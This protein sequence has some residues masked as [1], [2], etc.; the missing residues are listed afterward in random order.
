MTVDDMY[1]IINFAINK[2]QNGTLIAEDFN[3]V[4]PLAESGFINYLLG[5]F[6]TYQNGR[7]VARVELGQNS[8]VRQRL[9]PIIKRAVLTI[10]AG[11]LCP[12]PANYIQADAMW[13]DGTAYK[14]VKWCDQDKW[15]ST[16]NSSIDKVATKPIY[17]LTDTG[18]EFAPKSIGVASLSYV[19][20]PTAIKWAF[21]LDVN[22]RRVYDASANSVQPVW[23]NVAIMEI[24]VRA[25]ALI[26]I[27]LQLREVESYSQLIKTQGQ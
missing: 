6:Q 15:Y 9:S 11:G 14:R 24:I 20:Q 1:S 23:N 18:F 13:T 5:T 25:L 17:M 4:I 27:N 22:G 3:R 26:G 8:I 21:T 16:V 12:Y 10:D 2:N 19:Q 7:P